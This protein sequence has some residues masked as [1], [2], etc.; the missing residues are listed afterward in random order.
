MKRC[1]W[2][3]CVLISVNLFA[4][5]R[6]NVWELSY[7]INFNNPNSEIQ[8]T[9]GI[10][11][12]NAIFR[13]MAMA[14]TN[15]SI[16]DSAGNLILYTNGISI[17]N[18]N[19][20]TLENSVNFNEGEQTTE[21]DLDGLVAC[22]GAIFIPAP[23]SNK[24]YYVFY[25]TGKT[26]VANNQLETQ[27]LHLSYSKIDLTLDNGNGA[28]IDGFKNIHLVEDTLNWGRITACKHAN[29]RDWWI[30]VHRYYSDLFYKFLLTPDQI[31]GPYQQEI[32]SVVTK[33][34]VGQSTFSPD[35][36]KYAMVSPSN[37]IDYLQ[38]DRCTGD[39]YDS[40]II[41]PPDSTVG[42]SGCSFSPNSRFLYASALDIIYQY[43]TWNADMANS[44]IKIATWDGFTDF[45]TPVLFFNHQLAPDN[46]IYMGTFNGASYLNIINSPDSFGLSC[47]FAPHS[48]VLPYF[49]DNVPNLPNYD[50]GP[51]EG[52]PCD[53]LFN[54][55][56]IVSI[57][58]SNF[59]LVP[60]PAKEWLNIIY[61]TNEDCLLTLHD[62]NGKQ[63]A[64][65][66][67]FH[68]FKNRLLNVSE[69]PPG[70]YLAA[71]S[72]QGERV[73]SEKVMV[74]R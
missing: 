58:E 70:V 30:V 60:N 56:P 38:F 48:F 39:F 26:F 63:V 59:R 19:Y 71:V 10:A 49:N 15:A 67:L 23:D 55:T 27:P 3:W 29:G 7:S 9:N 18:R 13:I 34:I 14:F 43:D 52:S 8:F 21:D 12:T 40:Q 5:N 25:I 50:L 46:K 47:D 64:S 6:S 35:G 44:V 11:D 61:S 36:S 65:V 2:I 66:S 73:W 41:I 57:D 54:S 68:Y 37:I 32:G 62:I 51:L 42:V 31:F 28:I 4:Q 53:T 69:L 45:G 74:Q 24:Q 20:D 33:D 22:Q 1:Y 72:C 17:G 16:C